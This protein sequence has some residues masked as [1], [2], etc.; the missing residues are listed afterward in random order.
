[1][2]T[3]TCFVLRK[4]WKHCTKLNLLFFIS[5]PDMLIFYKHS[6]LM[7]SCW[8]RKN[9]KEKKLEFVPSLLSFWIISFRVKWLANKGKP[10][11]LKGIACFMQ[12]LIW[13]QEW[14]LKTVSAPLPQSVKYY[15]Y[16]KLALCLT[17]PLLEIHWNSVFVGHLVICK[18][19]HQKLVACSPLSSAY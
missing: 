1:M 17:A 16:L 7:V 5:L 10:W 12:I 8:L 15:T 2:Y 3:H 18:W 4:L 13:M 14:S 11:L 19:N 9:L 6:L